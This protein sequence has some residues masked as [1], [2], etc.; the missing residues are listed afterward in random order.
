MTLQI[1]RLHKGS[2]S[3]WYCPP[4]LC[5]LFGLFTLPGC[6]GDVEHDNP[7]DPRSDTYDPAGGITGVVV[8]RQTQAVSGAEI[9]IENKEVTASFKTSTDQ[10]GGYAF[11]RVSPGTY[12]LRVEKAGF[13]RLADSITV[14]TFQD[15]NK[16][17]MLNGAP[18]FEE[19][20]I[21]SAHISR[22]W[23]P[24]TDFTLLEIATHITDSDGVIDIERVWIEVPGLSVS[25]TLSFTEDPGVFRKELT[26]QDLGLNDM[27]EML[28]ENILLKARDRL[29]AVSEQLPQT[30]ARI[31]ADT[32]QVVSPQAGTVIGDPQP[33]LAWV[34]ETIPYPFNYQVEVVRIDDVIRNT[35]TVIPNLDPV[36]VC[37]DLEGS[38]EQEGNIQV[39][40]SLSIGSYF[41]TVSIVDDF[42]NWSRSKEAGFVVN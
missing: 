34:C 17:L 38:S 20:N 29:G 4:Y 19:V 26:A 22:V 27:Q 30:I 6:F 3:R 32:P 23:P 28:G 35:V 41:W 1:D 11:E 14:T 18:V 13:A 15:L 42:G 5:F 21:R 12:D 24:P 40:V 39:D 8:N 16:N 36:D 9:V 31:I 10:L 37:V 7:F 25:D 2:M 33:T